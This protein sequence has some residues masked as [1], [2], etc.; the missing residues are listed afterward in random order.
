MKNT[1]I[2]FH[3]LLKK[4]LIDNKI[5]NKIP[6]NFKKFHTSL[7]KLPSKYITIECVDDPKD[8]L[9]GV[10]K[11]LLSILRLNFEET[12]YYNQICAD[13]CVEHYITYITHVK[14]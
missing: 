8:I 9:H 5:L 14:L 12:N 1:H 10:Y 6:D 11:Y 3:L 13:Y 2:N 4:K 7:N